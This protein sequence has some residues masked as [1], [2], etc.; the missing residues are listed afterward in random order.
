MA[1]E[2]SDIVYICSQMGTKKELYILPLQRGMKAAKIVTDGLFKKVFKDT[3]WRAFVVNSLAD[4]DGKGML[5]DTEEKY[6]DFFENY[7]GIDFS[8]F[9]IDVKNLR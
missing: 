5:F 8:G 6:Y 2:K 4:L 3:P 1:K 9:L 7:T